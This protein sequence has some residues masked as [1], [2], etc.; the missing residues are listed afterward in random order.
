IVGGGFP[1]MPV[2]R[3]SAPASPG[4]LPAPGA[5]SSPFGR[6]VPAP[7]S[8]V[9]S[10]AAG[11]PAGAPPQKPRAS[12]APSSGARVD[13]F[14]AATAV[15]AGDKRVTLVIDDSAVKEDEIGRKSRGRTIAMAVTFILLGLAIG[16][17]IGNTADKRTQ[18]R[19][20]VRDGKDIYAR[21][22]EVSKTVETARDLVKKAVDESSGGPGKKASVDFGSIEQLV[23]MK[24]P[25]SANEF[26]RRL[27]R[28]FGDNVVDDLFDYYNDIN[29]LWDG[30]TGL[31]AKLA[32]PARHEAL[33]KSAAATDGLLNTDYGMVLSK[34][35]DQFA[36]GLVFVNIP[37]QQPAAD[38]AA[39][40]KPAKGK[41]TGKGKDDEGVKVTVSSSQGGQE[42]ERTLYSGQ[43]LGDSF[44]KY[45]FLI[46][47]VRSRTI[48]GES[49]NLFSK[50]RADLMELN[51]RMEKTIEVQGRLIK[52][53][54]PIAQMSE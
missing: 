26:H 16:F 21:I 22:N 49:A 40:K 48:L 4:G 37:P 39:D 20:A 36:G 18:Y 54:G 30:F 53:L 8:S 41:G 44:E 50:F 12:A 42:V 6:A 24:R 35:G 52:G 10:P 15:P 38:K 25:F 32:G 17:G 11:H 29:L 14:A 34:N 51:T 47:K 3:P 2:G 28:A 9:R 23:A 27:Y 31:G 43:E 46:D 45:A 7:S 19:L 1:G 13:P 33:A 5:A